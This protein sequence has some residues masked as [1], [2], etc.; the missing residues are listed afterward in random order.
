MASEREI[1]ITEAINAIQN[2]QVSSMRAAASRF[3]P[4][5]LH[6]RADFMEPLIGLPLSRSLRNLQASK[7]DA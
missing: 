2:G 1:A 5:G 4:L 7:S 6:Y 3:G